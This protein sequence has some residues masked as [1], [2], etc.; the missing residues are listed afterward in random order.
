MQVSLR[1][2]NVEQALRVLN[3]DRVLGCNGSTMRLDMD[4]PLLPVLR[5][6]CR[7]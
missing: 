1:D 6:L 4:I 7:T 3:A 5:L 2:N